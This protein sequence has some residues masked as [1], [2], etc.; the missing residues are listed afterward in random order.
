MSQKR[1][2]IRELLSGAVK[3]IKE[4]RLFHACRLHWSKMKPIIIRVVLGCVV[5][6]RL[7]VPTVFSQQVSCATDQISDRSSDSDRL[8]SF[9]LGEN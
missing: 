1:E 3:V 6:I 8:L 4:L 5:A 7:A 2:V 9:L